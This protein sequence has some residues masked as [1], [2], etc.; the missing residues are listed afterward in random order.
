LGDAAGL[1]DIPEGEIPMYVMSNRV[2]QNGAATMAYPDALADFAEKVGKSLYIIP[3]SI[4][5]V[6]LIPEAG[7]MGGLNSMVQE[8]NRS[9]L[10]PKEVLADHVYYY[11]KAERRIV[12]V[13][14]EESSYC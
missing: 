1:A 3:S 13:L 12:S 4:H 9:E 2:R 11:D 7:H 5:E 14:R 6:L 8:V 10:N